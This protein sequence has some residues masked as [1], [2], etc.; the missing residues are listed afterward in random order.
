MD[1]K[2]LESLLNLKN[3]GVISQ[4]E[5]D[6]HKSRILNE[7]VSSFQRG[8]L[9][10]LEENYFL[11]IMHLSLFCGLIIPIFGQ[12]IP[13]LLWLHNKDKN[14]NVDING[15]ILL[16]WIFSVV[17]YTVSGIVL[18]SIIVGLFILG[19]LILINIIFPIIGALKA[20]KGIV[21]SYP[22]SIRFFDINER[23]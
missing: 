13:I 11:M 19:F 21:W 15:R 3:A 9:L 16:N 1:F 4:E 10:N 17:I 23:N 2:N 14:K 6:L 20:K 18:C 5:F 7:K 12:I 22:L 8:M